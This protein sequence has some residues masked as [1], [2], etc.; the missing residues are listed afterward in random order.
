MDW[1]AAVTFFFAIRQ[2]TKNIVSEMERRLLDADSLEFLRH[3]CGAINKF[4]IE[5]NNLDRC[6]HGG[7]SW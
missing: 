6:Q 3:R 4:S 2:Q 7:S 5:V 1:R